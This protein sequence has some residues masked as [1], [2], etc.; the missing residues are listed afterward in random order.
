MIM[1]FD[2]TEYRNAGDAFL[3]R[4]AQC[5]DRV[6]VTISR[7][8]GAREHASITFAELARRARSRAAVLDARLFPGDRVVIALSTCIEFVELYLGCLMAGMT[9][10]PAPA[11]GGSASATKRIA[12]IVRDCAPALAITTH[13]G[14]AVLAELLREQ[15]P[16]VPV[17]EIWEVGSGDVPVLPDRSGPD[18][19]A[20]LQ[21]SSGSI[22]DPKG[23]MLAHSDILANL[24]VLGADTGLGPEDVVGSWLP[25]YHDMGLFC[26][27]TPALFFG[28]SA[29][30]MSPT[31]FVRRPVEWLRMM[32][33]RAVT[34]TAAPSFAYDLCQRAIPGEQVDGID[35]SRLRVAFNGSEPI[36]APA[37][38]AFSRRFATAGLRA[39]AV[40]PGYGLAECTVYV[41]SKPVGEPPTVLVADPRQLASAE[42][43]ELRLVP[44]GAGK[45]MVGVGRPSGLE[46]R[47]VD[48]HHR[49][50]LPDGAIGEIWLRGAGI[51]RGYWNQRELSEEIFAAQLEGSSAF[52]P[53][54]LRTGDLGALSAGELFV[55][56]RIK[57]MMTIY[58]RNLYP[59]DLEEEARASHE[60][61]CGFAGAA[62]GVAAPDEQI[63]LV[64]EVRP[65]VPADELPVI[66][67]AIT[68]RLTI[69][70]GAPVHNVILVR[71]G[72]IRR[73]T[74]GKIQR[75]LTR[76][77]FLAGEIEPL[78]ANLDPNILA[79]IGEGIR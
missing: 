30:L 36:Y 26:L 34:I 14:R 64:H 20:A 15:G 76:A 43:P 54:W 55:T 68:R 10:V 72:A 27:L 44:E 37:M 62:F 47:I 51:G 31:D 9:A 18:T 32:H 78:Y 38:T 49:R 3:S 40:A 69:S 23:V 42:R 8:T 53:G 6:A 70:A 11:P 57:E 73:T 29:V 7:A 39:D 74:S 71:R 61:L 41:S 67:S 56:G 28:A 12:G 4:A 58:G 60:A 17:E 21:Y 35:L 48:P 50:E 52:E 77:R 63:V 79:I 2:L 16:D 33:R 22:G 66:A 46:V 19:L 75:G 65:K 1:S 13:G 45:E 5:P 24:T 59:Q 25:L